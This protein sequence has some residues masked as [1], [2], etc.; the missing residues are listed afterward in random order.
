M[1]E[2][3]TE[4]S[5]H[6]AVEDEVDGVVEQCHDVEQI[7]E[8]P[9]DVVE[10]SRDEDRAQCEDALGQFADEEEGHDGQQHACGAV[11]LVGP[12]RLV[13]ASL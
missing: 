7:A 10:E 3:V 11:V 5:T 4:L 2:G 9:V 8:R 13:L 6:D 1:C 12:L